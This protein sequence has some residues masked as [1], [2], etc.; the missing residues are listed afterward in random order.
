MGAEYELKYVATPEGQA[1]VAADFP[2]GWETLVME[3]T[4]Y[5]TP[6]GALSEKR[7]TLRRRLENGCS[8]C[9]LK[10]PGQGNLRGEWQVNCADIHDA[11]SEL[12]LLGCPKDLPELCKEGLLPVCGASFTRRIKI[13]KL[14]GCNAE[15]ALD[16]GKLFGGNR[17]IP[18]CEME[19]EL[20]SGNQVALDA[21]GKEF[22]AKYN[23]QTEERSKFARALS[24]Y[25]E[26]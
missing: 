21:F 18:L 11:L 6:S 23:L 13:L 1:A 9:T 12:V 15:L 25:K 20:K 3:T 24:L 22:S 19:L 10:T 7:Y 8:V 26:V 17:E 4:Y 14:P 16:Q 5:D 2:G